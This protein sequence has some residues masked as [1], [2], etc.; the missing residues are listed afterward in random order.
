MSSEKRKSTKNSK[1]KSFGKLFSSGNGLI[2]FSR[3]LIPLKKRDFEDKKIPC[4]GY[5]LP[6]K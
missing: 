1:S 3:E 2:K 4:T 6:K 5:F